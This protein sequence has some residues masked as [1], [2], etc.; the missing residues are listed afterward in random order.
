MKPKKSRRKIY[1]DSTGKELVLKLPCDVGIST[2]ALIEEGRRGKEE[3]ELTRMLNNV[4]VTM[5]FNKA[6]LFTEATA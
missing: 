1:G 4:T 6:L 2:E 5:C 3:V